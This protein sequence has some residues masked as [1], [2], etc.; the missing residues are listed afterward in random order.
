MPLEMRFLRDFAREY[1]ISVVL[2]L[3]CLAAPANAAIVG[4][5]TFSNCG[6]HNDTGVCDTT[7]ESNSTFDASPVGSISPEGVYLSAVAGAPSSAA[8]RSG[9]GQ[10]A[11]T[12]FLNGPGFGGEAADLNRLIVNVPMADGT[13]GTRIGPVGSSLQGAPNGTSSW[14]FST[15]DNART[16]DFRVTNESDYYFVLDFLHF[17]A[18]VGNANSPRRLAIRYLAGDGT[19]FDNAL[20][21][22]TTGTE[23]TNLTALYDADLGSGPA[24][25][26]ISLD[27][28]SALATPVFLSPGQAAGFRFVW[29]DFQTNVAE[30]QVDNL[31]FEGRFFAT[32]SLTSEIDPVSVPEIPVTYYVSAST[33]NDLDDGLSPSTAFATLDRVNSILLRPGDR[34]LFRSGEQ[35]RGMFWPKGSGTASQPIEIGRYDGAEPPLLDGDGYQSSILI[36]DD[37]HYVIW[38]LALTNEADHL[39]SSGLPKVE[40]GF[41]GPANDDGSG[42]NVRFGLKVVA[43]SRS[44]TGFTLSDLLVRDIYPSPADVAQAHRGYGIK[45]ESQ[46]NAAAGE[47][48]TISS[49]D[50]DGLAVE[51]TGHYGVWIRPLGLDGLDDHK[52]ENFTLR[53]SNFLDTGGSGF[54]AVK[55]ANVLVEGNLFDRSGSHIDPRMWQRGSGLWAFD[56]RDVV[57]QHNEMRNARGPL[58]SYGVHIDYNNENVVVQFNYSY[59]NEGGFVQI[60]GANE[61]CGYRY[62]IS[63]RDGSR[64]EGVDG[65]LQNGRLVNVSN[66]CNIAAGCPSAGNFIYNNTIWVPNTMSPEISFRAGSGETLFQNNLIV[67]EEGSPVLQTHL[68]ESGVSYTISDNLFHPQVLFALAAPLT[69]SATFDDPDLLGAGTDDPA[70]YK[71]LPDSPAKSSG[72]PI[73]AGED[74]FGFLVAAGTA[75][76]L[77]AYNGDEVFDSIAVPSLSGAMRIFAVIVLYLASGSAL[78]RHL[79]ARVRKAS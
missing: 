15:N 69:Q 16:G 39:D 10:Q 73:A 9:R 76:H 31:A 4:W 72:I 21:E 66:F 58:D 65:A 20:F 5:Q 50:M 19:A 56:S 17:D 47:I 60:L 30:S 18:R 46:S 74:F 42:E 59:N 48:R 3:A 53:N 43:R 78:R 51:R 67:V 61:D 40:P 37:D 36:V 63:V 49:V 44:L 23:L 52:H 7:P 33:G 62:N 54:V 45:F 77:G 41:D 64:V 57:I 14:K 12:S 79:S 22:V 34:I 2:I 75:P 28:A 71:L 8:G 68:A 38:G 55:A 6:A 35:W 24:T 70:S 26:E 32:A 11:N 13:P 25:A 27:V 1:A 29:S